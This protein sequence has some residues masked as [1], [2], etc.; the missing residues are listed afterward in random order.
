[1]EIPVIFFDHDHYEERLRFGDALVSSID[2]LATPAASV[3]YPEDIYPH[4]VSCC[5]SDYEL[6]MQE[7][8]SVLTYILNRALNGKHPRLDIRDFVDACENDSVIVECYS[9]RIKIEFEFVFI[10]TIL[11]CCHLYCAE[12]AKQLHDDHYN[13]VAFEFKLQMIGLK[14][15]RDVAFAKKELFDVMY[16]DMTKTDFSAAVMSALRESKVETLSSPEE[17]PHPVPDEEVP[18]S[19]R[20]TANICLLLLEHFMGV[21]EAVLNEYGNKKKQARLM[22]LITGFAHKTCSNFHS[23]HSFDR[24]ANAAVIDE[25]NQLLSDLKIDFQV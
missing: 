22:E 25:I 6:D 16:G 8:M 5:I 1:M 4:V 14:N 7:F 12:L 2:W 3:S 24:E 13:K 23:E 19:Q 15:N 18:K 20:L 21:D 17:T 9:Y 10:Y 11:W